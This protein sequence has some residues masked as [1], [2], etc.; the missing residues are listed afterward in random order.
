ME[1]DRS[2]GR[3]GGG[4]RGCRRHRNGNGNS[5]RGDD[6]YRRGMVGSSCNSVGSKETPAVFTRLRL[7]KGGGRM[8]SS[9]LPSKG[10]SAV[11]MAWEKAVEADEGGVRGLLKARVN[12]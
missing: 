9:T 6:N 2:T 7:C 10:I 1:A 8:I 11:S 3:I 4:G 5:N 12:Q